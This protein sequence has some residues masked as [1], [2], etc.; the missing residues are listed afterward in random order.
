MKANVRRFG[1]SLRRPGA[2][3]M[4]R[5]SASSGFLLKGPRNTKEGFRRSARPECPALSNWANQEFTREIQMRILLIATSYNGLC[6]RAHIELEE[7]GHSVSVSLPANEEEMRVGGTTFPARFDYLSILESESA[8]GYL[9]SAY[10]HN[11]SSRNSRGPRTILARLGNYREP[12]NLGSDSDTG[13]Q[14][15][16]CRRYLVICP[17]R[18][19]CR[20]QSEYLSKR[21]YRS[22]DASHL[23]HC[24]PV[25]D[26]R[27]QTRA[28]RLFKRQRKGSIASLDEASGEKD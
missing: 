19:A 14:R 25:S 24:S 7:L 26:N 16:G 28:A 23:R 8:R 22:C 1:V 20:M 18:N 2:R 10:L 13:I 11:H 5:E 27:F 12:K 6:Q 3:L 21:G 9:E 4:C 15:N 17:L